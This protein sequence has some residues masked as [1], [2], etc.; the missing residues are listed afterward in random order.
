MAKSRL[1]IVAIGIA[2]IVF[3][4]IRLMVPLAWEQTQKANDSTSLTQGNVTAFDPSNH[5]TGTVEYW[6]N[7]VR[8]ET[9][10][11]GM[12]SSDLKS[13]V[14]VHYDPQNPSVA[15]VGDPP[16]SFAHNVIGIGAVVMMML[17]GVLLAA[18]GGSRI[19][20]KAYRFNPPPELH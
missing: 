19:S 10:S 8:Y 5:C 2:W 12:R 7:G 1:W 17:G 16:P 14:P 3:V 11:S 15:Y 13:S 9:E 4:P 6:V 20:S 18:F